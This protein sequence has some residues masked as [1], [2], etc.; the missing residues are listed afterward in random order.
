M[1]YSIK[2]GTSKG[3]TEDTKCLKFVQS[4]LLSPLIPIQNEKQRAIQPIHR[5]IPKQDKTNR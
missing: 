4:V 2:Y 3:N 5:T 1:G